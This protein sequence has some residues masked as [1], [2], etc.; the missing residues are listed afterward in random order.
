MKLKDESV[1]VVKN[2]FTGLFWD[3]TAWIIPKTVQDAYNC[4]QAFV[5]LP[6]L[7]LIAEKSNTNRNDI[8][9]ARIIIESN[10]V[11]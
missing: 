8:G 6:S 5:D 3:G 11:F 2:L 9:G 4:K 1:I 10:L 7:D